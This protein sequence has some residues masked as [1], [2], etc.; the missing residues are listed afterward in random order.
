MS[1]APALSPSRAGDFRQCPLMFRLR[2]IDR[3]PEPPSIAPNLGTLVHQVLED[4]YDR[5]ARERTVETSHAMVV[6]A[7]EAMTA[8][9]PELEELFETPRDLEQFIAD[10]RERLSTYFTMENP[11]RLEPAGREEFVEYR[12][13]DGPNLRGVIDRVDVAPDGSIRIVDYKTGRTPHPRYGQQAK[14]QM[15]FY[16][17]L[18]ERLRGR[19]PTL[20]QLLYLR[21]GGTVVL[22]PTDE[23]LAMVEHEIREL[24]D[25]IVAAA[26]AGDFRTQ[27]SRLCDWC[28]F[29]ALCPEFGGTPP[30]LEI[31]AVERALG[32]TPGT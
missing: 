32:V 2:V 4:I 11:Q 9:D 21:D 1:R 12:L 20:L 30:P 22:H 5:P 27:K 7:W 25:A 13:D 26:R 8:K 28:S 16:A 18:V 10:A 17:L 23:D 19:R 15:R 6:P 24:W 3:V 29:Q 14:F 31:A